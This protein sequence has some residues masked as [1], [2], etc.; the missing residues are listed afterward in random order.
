MAGSQSPELTP[1]VVPPL[2]PP[3]FQIA[4]TA[5]Q[6]GTT[7]DIE[8]FC[9]NVTMVQWSLLNDET[10]MVTVPARSMLDETRPKPKRV[11]DA[12]VGRLT[13]NEI[14]IFVPTTHAQVVAELADRTREGRV[15]M[16]WMHN[17][18][19]RRIIDLKHHTTE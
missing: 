8:G 5:Q 2:G 19:M 1:V 15:V 9:K 12:L 13:L 4:I 6:A 16:G 7:V 10:R 17:F 14:G 18:P 3:W 11:E